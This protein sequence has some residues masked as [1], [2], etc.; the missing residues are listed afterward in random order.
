MANLNELPLGVAVRLSHPV[1]VKAHG[2]ST[3]AP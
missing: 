1:V 3:Y 2:Q